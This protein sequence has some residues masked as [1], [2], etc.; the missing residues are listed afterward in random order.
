ML[1]AACASPKYYYKQGNY[2]LSIQ[3]AVE[4]LN[5]NPNKEKH[6]QYLHK[7]YLIANIKDNEKIQFL[8]T[9]GQ[10]DVWDK[11]FTT[12]T[13]LNKRQELVR[14]LPMDI[15]TKINFQLINYD[16]E[17]HAAKR[18][19]AEYFYALGLKYLE[20]NNR[21]SAQKAY[22]NFKTVKSYYPNF[23]DV[24]KLLIES[25]NQGTTNILFLVENQTNMII[26]E[27]FESDLLQLSLFD[28]NVLFRNY[29]SNRQHKLDF[30][31]IISLSLRHINISPE[32]I[33]EI[34]YSEAKE[35]EDGFQYVLDK[36]GNVMKDS[37]GND[38]K[39][40]KYTN[41]ICQIVETEQF[42]S[43]QVS[44]MLTIRNAMNTVLLSE[45]I[46]AEWNFVNNFIK[47]SGNNKAMTDKTRKKLNNKPLPFPS[48]E[49]MILQTTDAIKRNCKEFIKRNQ[50]IF[51]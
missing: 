22:H 12:Y 32:R 42:K 48:D 13:Q 37:L 36:N 24:D 25:E 35:V 39:T 45:P 20:E 1:F 43:V 41:L 38:I 49:Y 18:N 27:R 11:I 31:Y 7:S 21:L 47:Y 46:G 40:P 4:K 28:L 2:D 15:L 5:K 51:I 10:A 8:K 33:K 17:I 30:H 16:N 34:H 29:Y 19:A 23:K 6:I 50:H 26:P 44:G 9:S 3:K 14:F